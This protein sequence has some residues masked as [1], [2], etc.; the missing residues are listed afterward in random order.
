MSTYY[1]TCCQILNM[2]CLYPIWFC[3]SKCGLQFHITFQSFSFLI[4]LFD[5]I[6]NKGRFYYRA[7]TLIWVMVL[8]EQLYGYIKLNGKR[9]ERFVRA[10][11]IHNLDH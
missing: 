1:K 11:E 7:N 6:Y 9:K 4:L 8:L 5:T 2:S 3:L 10:E